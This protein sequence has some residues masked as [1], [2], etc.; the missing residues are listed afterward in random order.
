MGLI[1]FIIFLLNNP[2]QNIE[3]ARTMVFATIVSMLVIGTYNFRSLR[4]SVLV[5]GVFNNRFLI[6]AVLLILSVTLFVMYYPVTQAIFQLTPLKFTDWLICAGAACLN[7]FYMETI[8]FFRRHME[9]DDIRN[10]K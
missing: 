10:F 1:A 5:T 9:K 6:I 7:L 2:S 3:M 8:K 4:E